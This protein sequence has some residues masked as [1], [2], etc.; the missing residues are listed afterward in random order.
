MGSQVTTRL[1]LVYGLLIYRSRVGVA[2]GQQMPAGWAKLRP[3]V[4]ILG[5][6]GSFIAAEQCA[7]VI[8][9]RAFGILVG[10]SIGTAAVLHHQQRQ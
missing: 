1:P 7:R 4:H 9:V 5:G 2:S 3:G 10:G 8:L 6:L